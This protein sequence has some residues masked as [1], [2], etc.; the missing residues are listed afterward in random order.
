MDDL[1]PKRITISE[2]EAIY[3]PRARC[4]LDGLAERVKEWPAYMIVILPGPFAK[5][6]DDLLSILAYSDYDGA[7][8][9]FQGYLADGLAARFFEV[10]PDERQEGASDK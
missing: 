9:Q 3:P 7:C 4:H 5:R 2:L 10:W 6:D 1:S 8:R